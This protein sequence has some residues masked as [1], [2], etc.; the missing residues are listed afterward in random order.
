[1]RIPLTG[2]AFPRDNQTVAM[3]IATCLLR[4]IRTSAFSWRT[5]K[6]Q[7]MK[8]IAR[9]VTLVGGRYGARAL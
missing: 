5:D 2:G 3:T 7:A 8:S 1:M 4:T 6:K 9:T